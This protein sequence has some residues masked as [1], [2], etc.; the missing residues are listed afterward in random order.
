MGNSIIVALWT[1][2]GALAKLTDRTSSLLWEGDFWNQLPKN[3]DLS[4]TSLINMG[5]PVMILVKFGIKMSAKP[6]QS[7]SSL[8]ASL[9]SS[10]PAFKFLAPCYAMGFAWL[11]KTH[12]AVMLQM[13]VFLA[14]EGIKHDNEGYFI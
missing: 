10:G 7:H 11:R 4:R 1:L 14:G 5:Q 9:A 3:Q 2:E 12:L 6:T 8:T 13:A